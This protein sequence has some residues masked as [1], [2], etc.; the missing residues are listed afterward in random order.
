MKHY[1]MYLAYPPTV[2]LRSEG[3]GRHTAAFLKAAAK[4]EDVRFV[5]L[6]PSW[7]REAVQELCA[8]EGVDTRRFDL[9]TPDDRPVILRFYELLRSWRARSERVTI[10]RRLLSSV[11]AGVDAHRAWLET[12]LAGTK[13][14]PSFVVLA[15][16]AL[17]LVVIAAPAVLL[18]LLG[19]AGATG[20]R[21]VFGRLKAH[22]V[23]AAGLSWLRGVARQ[24]QNNSLM[25][26][27]YRLMDQRE[28]DD[29]VRIA[30]GMKHV[31]AWYCPTAFWPSFNGIKA[32]RLL[33]VPD[34]VVSDF[35]TEFAAIGGDRLMQSF[36]DI[37]TTVR[38]VDRIVTYSDNVKWETLVRQRHVRPETIR[39]IRHAPS[40]LNAWIEVTG[41]PDVE[42]ASRNYCECLFGMALQ[43]SAYPEGLGFGNSAARF[44]FYASQFRPNKNVLTLLRAYEYL[45]RTRFVQHKLVLTGSPET[46]PA[47]DQFIREHGL[48]RD[49]L[50]LKGLSVPELAAC[51]RLADLAV[52][53]TLSEGG[54]PFTFTEALSVGTPVVMSR[55]PVALEVLDDASLQDTT[56]FDPYDWR[57]VAGR[58]EW[59]IH[60]R[61]HLLAIQHPVF[62]RLRSRGWND[63]VDEY[64]DLLA[65]VETDVGSQLTAVARPAGVP[66]E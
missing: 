43:R 35:P 26:R 66:A 52:C 63:V 37:C 19:K 16:Y 11:V 2:E 36:E 34:I 28:S 14:V 23:G 17:L 57:D 1:G 64:L 50:C 59:G 49:V 12:S 27:L 7:S 18:Y 25:Y 56:F 40:V 5:V 54:C 45:L 9:V 13:S 15:A 46:L 51:Y 62:E 38:G 30:N 60:N 8:D 48:Q 61:E 58:I 47:I 31:S 32:P 65:E 33:C 24:P 55:I 20:F 29:L 53:P 10:L 3:L 4:R 41:F 21:A 42:A 22:P 39:V 6:C 44:I